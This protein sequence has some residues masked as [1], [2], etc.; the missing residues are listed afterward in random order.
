[1]SYDTVRFMVNSLIW[2]IITVRDLQIV[3]NGVVLSIF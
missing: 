3:D 1:M 2:L